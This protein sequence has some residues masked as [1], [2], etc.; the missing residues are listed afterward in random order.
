MQKV[1]TA[2]HITAY[3]IRSLWYRLVEAD[4][5]NLITRYQQLIQDLLLNVDNSGKKL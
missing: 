4:D 3:K 1:F 5:E 2:R